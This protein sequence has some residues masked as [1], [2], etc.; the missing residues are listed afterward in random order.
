MLIY[1][2][3]QSIG[4]KIFS[5]DFKKKRKNKKNGYKSTVNRN[6]GVIQAKV[7][8]QDSRKTSKLRK[9]LTKRNKQ[10][11]EGLGFKVKQ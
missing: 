10:F 8:G 1:H 2:T 5:N 7:S 9:K 4:S 6:Q 11:L 3:H